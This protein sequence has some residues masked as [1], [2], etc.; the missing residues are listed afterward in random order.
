MVLN[1]LNM[2]F[3]FLARSSAAACE[4]MSMTH[5]RSSGSG[6]NLQQCSLFFCSVNLVLLAKTHSSHAFVPVAAHYKSLVLKVVDLVGSE[7]DF[8]T[9]GNA[10]AL[11]HIRRHG[12]AFTGKQVRTV[13][14][15]GCE[16]RGCK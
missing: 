10:L 2:A 14:E 12:L 13:A 8:T 4:K 7:T 9:T 15:H 3:S 5:L 6:Q 16:P 11:L 1:L